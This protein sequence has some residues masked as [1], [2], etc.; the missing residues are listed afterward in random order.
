MNSV[1]PFYRSL[2]YKFERAEQVRVRALS[3][4]RQRIPG[5]RNSRLRWRVIE[6]TLTPEVYIVITTSLK[7][8]QRIKDVFTGMFDYEVVFELV[9]K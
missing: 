5:Y 1:D 7:P 8:T 9:K 2:K 3:V 4:F 6:E